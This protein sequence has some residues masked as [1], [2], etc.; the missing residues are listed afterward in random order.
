MIRYMLGGL[1]VL[2]IVVMAVG[3]LTGRVRARSCCPADPA[4]DRRMRAAMA[5][6]AGT[7]PAV[8]HQDA[9]HRERPNGAPSP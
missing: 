3:A 7:E 6:L 1:V 5:P 4:R 9:M 2:Y 8:E